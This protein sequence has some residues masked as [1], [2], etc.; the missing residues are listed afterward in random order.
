[1]VGK[2]VSHYR[3][4]EKIGAGGMGEVFLAEDTRL[5]RKA[6]LKFLPSAFAAA[7]ESRQRFER[8]AQA[9]A[10]LNH[11]NIV[12][13]YE[14]GEHEDQLFIAMEYVQGQTL[15]A[16]LKSNP[17][18]F[19]DVV[20]I[21]GQICEG[22]SSA[23]ESGIVHRD[24]KPSNLLLDSSGRVRIL[25]FGLA[26][27]SGMTRLTRTGTAMGTLM[28]QSPEQA[29]GETVDF[30]TDIYSLGCVIY[31]MI[32]GV[33]PFHSEYDAAIVYAIA[34]EPPEPLSVVRPD[35][36]GYLQTLVHGM[37]AKSPAERPQS[38]AEV[39][40]ALHDRHATPASAKAPAQ[41]AGPAGVV[42]SSR[43]KTSGEP[44]RGEPKELAAILPFV[45]VTGNIADE[46]LGT[47][48]SETIMADLKKRSGLHFV[49]ADRVHQ[50]AAEKTL[51]GTADAKLLN[52]GTQLGARWVVCGSYQR[53]G[54]SVRI[55]ASIADTFRNEVM[56]SCKIDGLMSDVF[57]LQ[58]RVVQELADSMEQS[59]TELNY[60]STPVASPGRNRAFELYARGRQLFSEFNLK[61]TAEAQE[62]FE[63]AIAADPEYAL[64]YSGLGSL[65][66]TRFIHSNDSAD[67]QVGIKNLR[68]AIEVDDR[69]ADP[70]IWLTYAYMRDGK[71]KESVEVGRK[72]VNLD[73]NHPLGHYFLG[74]AYSA[75]ISGKYD[76]Q[77]QRRAHDCYSRCIAL[78]PRYQ[79][80]RM[81]IG[82]MYINHGMYDRA[83]PHLQ[84]AAEIEGSERPAYV[85]FVGGP[86]LL[87]GLHLR[88]GDWSKAQRALSKATKNLAAQDHA[89]KLTFEVLTC[90]YLGELAVGR[91]SFDEALQPYASAL[92]FISEHPEGLGLGFFSIRANL[93]L[94]RAFH[95][96]GM[97]REANSHFGSAQKSFTERKGMSFQPVFD[98][99][100]RQAHFD[101]A[102]Y[103]STAGEKKSAKTH[104]LEAIKLG[105]RETPALDHFPEFDPLR[106]DKSLKAQLL[107]IADD[108]PFQ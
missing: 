58:D 34:H 68:M 11:P 93:G 32:A 94:A 23:H 29:R 40:D 12:A 53:M 47:G 48:L 21:A 10:A 9:A 20:D 17:P 2:Q 66:M 92:E 38:A 51:S 26:R 37:L 90:C 91:G 7:S 86:T 106:A 74:A 19:D 50:I 31:E 88:M 107:R 13:V 73:P 59:A 4:L 39:L 52:L 70:L 104:L 49:A 76:I 25:D 33:P 22:L 6:A 45:N 64:A 36:P 54:D 60:L 77:A 46:W 82:L 67:L 27:L 71:P 99:G 101:F 42:E 63:K 87:G 5:K 16:R 15:E 79:P 100:E 56:E 57:T 69:L 85:K 89:Y 96:L 44:T 65:L 84:K 61:G 24:I 81:L 41:I 30:R 75:E 14:L 98:G 78:E 18:S 108:Q 55:I 95:R 62:Y 102:I 35:V 103:F 28:Y 8:E 80:V 43:P 72:A 3:I 105:W 1:M 83:L 97:R